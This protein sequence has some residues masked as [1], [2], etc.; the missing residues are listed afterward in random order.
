MAQD[1]SEASIHNYTF[2][3]G[4]GGEL[5]LKFTSNINYTKVGTTPIIFQ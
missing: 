4:G 3:R 2:I 1:T 5:I